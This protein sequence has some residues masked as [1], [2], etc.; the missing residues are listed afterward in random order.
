M[1]MN[2]GVQSH[3]TG[4]MAAAAEP[5]LRHC[6]VACPVLRTRRLRNEPFADCRSALCVRSL[7][8]TLGRARAQQ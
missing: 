4:T 3:S 6:S 5:W 7:N 2:D 1:L 8:S